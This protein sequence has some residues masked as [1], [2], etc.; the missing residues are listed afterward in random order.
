MEY[1]LLYKQGSQFSGVLAC[2]EAEPSDLSA[3]VSRA[4]VQELQY[5]YSPGVLTA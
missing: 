3:M 4:R 5:I 2:S 1:Q